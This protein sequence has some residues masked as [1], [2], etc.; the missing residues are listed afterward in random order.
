MET[1][2]KT[3]TIP[4]YF[5]LFKTLKKLG[6]STLTDVHH[7]CRITYAHLH[8]MKNVFLGKE[9]ITKER[10]GV[11]IFLQLT[12]SGSAIVSGIDYLL[13]K[14]NISDDDIKRYR[15]KTKRGHR[16]KNEAKKIGGENSTTY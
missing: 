1:D 14:M 9:W 11:K 12:E 7:E 15:D 10:E 5:I 3:L 4:D 8:N 16:V 13:E 2:L 6:R